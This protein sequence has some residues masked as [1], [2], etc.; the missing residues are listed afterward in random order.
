MDPI[1][2]VYILASYRNGTLYTGVISDLTRR[3]AQHRDGSFG[4]FTEQYAVK[5]LVWHE[6]LADIETAIRR[7]K[8]IKRWR[9]AWK[10]ALIE[11]LNPDWRDL[12][13][14]LFGAE[15]GAPLER[16]KRGPGSSPQTPKGGHSRKNGRPC[17]ASRRKDQPLAG[18]RF[19]S[20][21]TF[22]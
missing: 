6:T 20:A 16:G 21:Q 18:L 17:A 9:R 10:I 13:P 5:T 2:F 11:E 8:P 14:T 3:I 1:G 22:L 12:W 4:G 15:P 19:K 7:E